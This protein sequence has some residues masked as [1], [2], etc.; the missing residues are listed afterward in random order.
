MHAP[1]FDSQPT[2]GEKTNGLGI[3][4]ALLL[5]D[6]RRQTIGGV[7]VRDRNRSLE[8][9]RPMIIFVVTKMNCAAGDLDP[10]CQHRL[11]NVMAIKS[12]SAE[13]GD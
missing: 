4:F 5:E 12:L 7:V 3:G 10:G 6:A 1:A 8:N 9:N 2:F 11:M 13:G